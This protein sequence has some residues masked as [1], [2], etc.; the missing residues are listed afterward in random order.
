MNLPAHDEA[1]AAAGPGEWKRLPFRPPSERF[2][3]TRRKAGTTSEFVHGYLYINLESDKNTGGPPKDLPFTGFV[4][5]YDEKFSTAAEAK[6]WVECRVT[7]LANS[8]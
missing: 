8:L 2:Q 5:G 3:F 4:C 1:L 7:V 6:A